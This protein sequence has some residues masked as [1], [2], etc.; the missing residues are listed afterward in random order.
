MAST[1]VNV[2]LLSIR[3][4]HSSYYGDIDENNPVVCA[5]EKEIKSV[6][7]FFAKKAT[8]ITAKSDTEACSRGYVIYFYV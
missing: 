7:S 2:A 6:L 3:P 5:S 4:A 1:L 8:T